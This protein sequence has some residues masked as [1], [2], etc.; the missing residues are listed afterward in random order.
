MKHTS[1]RNISEL[2]KTCESYFKSQRYLQRLIVTSYDFGTKT[3]FTRTDQDNI[4]IL[5]VHK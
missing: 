5:T 3:T 1:Y 2:T 4:Q